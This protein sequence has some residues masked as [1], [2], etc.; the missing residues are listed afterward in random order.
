VVAGEGIFLTQPEICS[1][2][3]SNSG[4]GRCCK[5]LLAIW[6][7]ALWQEMEAITGGDGGG[8]GMHREARGG[9]VVSLGIDK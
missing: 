2:G 9:M 5:D 8:N 7:R 1:H 3:E 6:T 4:P